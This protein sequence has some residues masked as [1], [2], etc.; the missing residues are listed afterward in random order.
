MP[1]QRRD[2]IEE[3]LAAKVWPLTTDWLAGAFTNV[4]FGEMKEPVPYPIFGLEKS[5]SSL[6]PE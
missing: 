1:Y 5:A 3:Y 4:K 2:L 6:I